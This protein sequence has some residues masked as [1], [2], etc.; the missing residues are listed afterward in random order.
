ML[1]YVTMFAINFGVTEGVLCQTQLM[2]C[3]W[4]GVTAAFPAAGGRGSG[5]ELQIW[6]SRQG[7]KECPGAGAVPQTPDRASLQKFETGN[8]QTRW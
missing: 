6:Y 8:K 3:V 7:R 1:L 2:V 5:Q 4:T